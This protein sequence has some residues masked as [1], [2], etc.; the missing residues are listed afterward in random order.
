MQYSWLE[1]LTKEGHVREE[2]RDRIYQDCGFILEK[3][4]TPSAAR[5]AEAAEQLAIMKNYLSKSFETVAS[6]APVGAG[7]LLANAVFSKIK[8]VQDLTAIIKNKAAVLASP[9]GAPYKD[10]VSARFD[11]LVKYAPKVATMPDLSKKLVLKALHS[12]FTDED[13]R[14]MSSLQASYSPEP[15][16]PSSMFG[17]YQ[18]KMS[19]AAAEQTTALCGKSLADILCIVKEASDMKQ[20]WQ[21]SKH[22]LATVGALTGAHLLIGL[23]SGAVNATRSMLDRKNLEASLKKSF[24]D[25]MRQSDPTR[26]PLHANKEKAR[27]AFQT[28]T[29]FAPHMA[30]EPSSARSFMNAMVAHDLGTPVGSVKELSEIERNLQ[31]TKGSNPFIEGLAAGLEASGF[32]KALGPAIQHTMEPVREQHQ[33]GVAEALYGQDLD[34]QKRNFVP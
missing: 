25:A 24:D 29:H 26:E 32:G 17:S 34:E 19:K 5:A 7:I 8:S 28:L 14:H 3:M 33:R 22:L 4:G 2:V 27:Q 9:E 15:L 10:K 13:V 16:E 1:K 11:E 21:A 6:L 23:G 20:K 30:A 18:K 31:G 12:G